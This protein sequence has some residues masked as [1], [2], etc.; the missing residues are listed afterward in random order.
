MRLSFKEIY[1]KKHDRSANSVHEIAPATF[2]TF[3]KNGEKY[4]QLDTYDIGYDI[5]GLSLKQSKHKLQFDKE[6][7]RKFINL[8]KKE[9]DIQ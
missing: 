3:K 2:Q 9:F 6:T 8:L 5:S 1:F 7:A 4:F